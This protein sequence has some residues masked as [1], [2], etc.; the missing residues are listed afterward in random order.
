MNIQSTVYDLLEHNIIHHKVP[1]LNY[2]L[3]EQ[4]LFYRPDRCIIEERK[5]TANINEWLREINYSKCVISEE[6]SYLL[7]YQEIH[8][9]D[10]KISK[11]VFTSK[12][13]YLKL[14]VYD[15]F[16]IREKLAHLIYELFN[17]QIDLSINKKINMNL[18][19]NN[20]LLK[21]DSIVIDDISWIDND[22]YDLIKR[23]LNTNFNNAK[24]K[25]IFKDI[26]HSFT[27]RSNPGIG[28]L[29]LLSFEYAFA[30]DKTQR[31]LENLDRELGKNV[32]GKK[33]RAT[34]KQPK[35]KQF[36]NNEVIKD[37]LEM[38]N[39]FIEGFILLLKNIQLLKN[40]IIELS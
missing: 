16:S 40:E 32:E 30:D 18:S 35:E 39:L 37:I 24:C 15:L 22:E 3:K 23:V 17:R 13:R 14:V 10:K 4:S 21:I 9:S 38:W 20:I 8:N 34:S 33:Y 19:F 11:Y 26:R 6:L 36:D 2:K 29:P 12:E 31:I 27:H 28:C 1:T 5:Y 25:Y 7:A